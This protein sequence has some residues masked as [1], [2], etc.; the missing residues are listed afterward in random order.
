MP[1]KC[2][3]CA[4]EMVE[5]DVPGADFK[6]I[7][8]D[9]CPGPDGDATCGTWY[10]HGEYEAIDPRL[11][12]RSASDALLNSARVLRKAEDAVL[13]CPRCT[14]WRNTPQPPEFEPP[15]EASTTLAR[16]E[17]VGVSL[18]LCPRCSGVWAPHGSVDAVIQALSLHETGEGRAS[19]HYRSAAAASVMRDNGALRTRCCECRKMVAFEESS[20]DVDGLVCVPCAAARARGEG[21][22][23]QIEPGLWGW[24]RWVLKDLGLR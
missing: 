13:R 6:T 23:D 2:P 10:D 1:L 15:S 9:R 7:Y 16:V 8:I 11:G 19:G 20:L 5:H 17:F 24:V 4:R 12:A 21:R 18:G 22:A 3:E 14:A